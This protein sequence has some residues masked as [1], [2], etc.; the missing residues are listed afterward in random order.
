MG[1]VR[2]I[3]QKKLLLKSF[4]YGYLAHSKFLITLSEFDIDLTNTYNIFVFTEI[5]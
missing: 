4:G 2:L 5:D 3:A 1:A